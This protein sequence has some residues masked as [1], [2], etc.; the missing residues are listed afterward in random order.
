MEAEGQAE[1]ADRLAK[2]EADRLAKEEAD[3]RAKLYRGAPAEEEK[4]SKK[5][6]LDDCPVCM[7]PIGGPYI[8]CSNGHATCYTCYS[9]HSHECSVCRE[10][11]TKSKQTMHMCNTGCGAYVAPMQSF[12]ER[13]A[14]AEGVRDAQYSQNSFDDMAIYSLLTISNLKQ[15]LAIIKVRLDSALREARKVD[16]NNV[17]LRCR[18]RTLEKKN[19]EYVCKEK[20]HVLEQK[21]AYPRYWACKTCTLENE[22][23][24]DYCDMCRTQKS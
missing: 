19:Q 10:S 20:Q 5:K 4:S 3:R 23:D 7:D 14:V 12:C 24:R 8:T 17:V 2:E 13:C 9:R 11:F 1:E 6:D 18:V 16:D 21:F 22:P 15:E